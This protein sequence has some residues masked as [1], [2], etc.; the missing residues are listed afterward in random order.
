MIMSKD[1]PSLRDYLQ[2]RHLKIGVILIVIALLL[3]IVSITRN[4]KT[5]DETENLPEGEFI[6]LRAKGTIM[7]SSVRLFNGSGQSLR[8]YNVT[9][10]NSDFDTLKYIDVNFTTRNITIFE[11]PSNEINRSDM[12]SSSPE[13][14]LDIS[15]IYGGILRLNDLDGQGEVQYSYELVYSVQPYRLLSIPAFILTMVGVVSFLR[16]KFETKMKTEKEEKGRE[17][18]GEEETDED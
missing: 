16:G 13:I 8:G 10:Y 14:V 17:R 15:N 7:D 9:L 5:Y 4:V 3:A 6:Q 18:Y 12:N 2:D 1:A 11:K